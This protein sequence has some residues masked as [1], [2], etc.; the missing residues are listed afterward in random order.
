MSDAVL[1]RLVQEVVALRERVNALEVLEAPKSITVHGDL[2]GLDANDHPQYL[3]PRMNLLTNG[4]FEVWQRGNGPFTVSGTYTA[5]RWLMWLDEGRAMTVWR[6]IGSPDGAGVCLN[7]GFD[8]GG[9]GGSLGG[10][11]FQKLEWLA[12]LKGRALSASVRVQCDA[13]RAVAI[14]IED[15]MG[16][17]ASALHPGDKKYHTLTATRAID[18]NA[19]QV[20]LS[21]WFWNSCTAYIDNAMLVVGDTPAPYAPLHPA[22][23]WQ[24]CQRY[25]EVH[26]GVADGFPRFGGY[27]AAAITNYQS[28]GFSTR[29]AVVPTVSKRGTWV[30][31]NCGQ[32]GVAAPGLMGYAIYTSVIGAGRFAA[33]PDSADDVIVAEANP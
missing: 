30:T 17:S 13:P 10:G 27:E 20:L 19:T 24:R 29:K 25:Y 9:L 31:T 8:A 5:D 21:V 12:E 23:E 3:L 22:E 11:L 1:E 2:D 32:P 33:T 18:A 26:G 4:G 15:G 6:N 28:V 7:A 14:V 16:N